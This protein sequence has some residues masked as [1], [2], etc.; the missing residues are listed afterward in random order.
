LTIVVVVVVVVAVVLAEVVVWVLVVAV[1]VVVAEL[2][3]GVT[4]DSVCAVV[5]SPVFVGSG[6]SVTVPV[7]EVHDARNIKEERITVATLRNTLVL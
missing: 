7:P 3:I 1:D 2:S 5:V 6:S 4:V